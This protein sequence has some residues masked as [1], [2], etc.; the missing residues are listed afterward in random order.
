M[1]GDQLKRKFRR[2][3]QAKAELKTLGRSP[4]SVNW[5]PSNTAGMIDGESPREVIH[6]LMDYRND[7]EIVAR[8]TMN[9]G[10]AAYYNSR[11]TGTGMAWSVKT[12]Y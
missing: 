12:G 3:V 4:K 7:N 8:A 10:R 1:Q 6:V 11:L 5:S 2:F 9:R